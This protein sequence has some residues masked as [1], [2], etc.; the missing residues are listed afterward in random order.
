MPQTSQIQPSKPRESLKERQQCQV[1]QI[2]IKNKI[3]YVYFLAPSVT[4]SSPDYNSSSWVIPDEYFGRAVWLLKK[5]A[6]PPKCLLK[7]DCATRSKQFLRPLADY[8][9]HSAKYPTVEE[10]R[11]GCPI[12]TSIDLYKQSTLLWM[13]PSPPIGF[14][15]PRDPHYEARGLPKP[16]LRSYLPLADKLPVTVLTFPKY[17]EAFI[18]LACRDSAG[19]WSL[20]FWIDYLLFIRRYEE[21]ARQRDPSLA[22]DNDN[23]FPLWRM[24]TIDEPYREYYKRLVYYDHDRI[25]DNDCG[26]QNLR[27]MH[28]TLTDL[29]HLP[30]GDGKLLWCCWG[31]PV[32]VHQR[33][34]RPPWKTVR[35]QGFAR[36]ELDLQ[37]LGT[38]HRCV[39]KLLLE[40][41]TL[42][43]ASRPPGAPRRLEP[44]E[45]PALSAPRASSSVY[46]D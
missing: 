12:S 5:K 39:H 32:L 41:P 30:K 2:F 46:S 37:K 3:P 44:P 17:I 16:G 23:A 18:M 26:T 14:V 11:R 20:K 1:A 33:Q 35:S 31:K 6:D 19:H 10:F 45:L 21:G 29:M 42:L 24:E 25:T 43:E 22:A 13:F 28:S 34:P 4:S 27:F 9:F 38:E 7:R 40:P 36:P 15:T 8:H